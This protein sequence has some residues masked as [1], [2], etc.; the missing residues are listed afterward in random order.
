MQARKVK[1]LITIAMDLLIL[2]LSIG[3]I[4]KF[5]DLMFFRK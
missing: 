5:D 3:Q 4:Q 2:N 1:I